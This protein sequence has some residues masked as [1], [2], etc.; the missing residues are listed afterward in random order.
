MALARILSPVLVQVKGLDPSFQR[1][2]KALIAPMR[3]GTLS[4]LP[5]RMAWLV[6]MSNHISNRFIQNAPVRGEMEM[7]AGWR[8]SQTLT[9]ACL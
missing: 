3:Q 2:M 9:L 8:A 4:K 1:F 6:R 7:K 5:L